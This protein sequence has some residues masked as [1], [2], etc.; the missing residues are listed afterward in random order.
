M[1]K[2]K[3]TILEVRVFSRFYSA[4]A[5]PQPLA[6]ALALLP[7]DYTHKY[8]KVAG[9]NTLI[10]QCLT[11]YFRKLEIP[12]ERHPSEELCEE[13]VLQIQKFLDNRVS[14]EVQT[15]LCKEF[16]QMIE[17]DNDVSGTETGNVYFVINDYSKAGRRKLL[18]FLAEVDSDAPDIIITMDFAN[19][20]PKQVDHMRLLLAIV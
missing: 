10:I 9:V 6:K 15:N 16:L 7:K 20:T 1:A 14:R 12:L 4:L 3:A 11:D 5:F 8:K 17:I 19:A 2:I 18:Q 13:V